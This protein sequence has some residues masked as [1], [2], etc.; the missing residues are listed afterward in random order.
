[1]LGT[2]NNALQKPTYNEFS[3]GVLSQL[4]NGM[5]CIP[6]CK[7]THSNA[8]R[9]YSRRTGMLVNHA[10]AAA[11]GAGDENFWL[12]QRNV[13]VVVVRTNY[14]GYEHGNENFNKKLLIPIA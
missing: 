7:N 9:L 1:M 10:S 5:L 14:V 11:S 6:R 8:S 3:A 13:I 2:I 12:L 4:L